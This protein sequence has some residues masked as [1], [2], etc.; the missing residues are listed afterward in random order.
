MPQCRIYHET[1][2][3]GLVAL[4][5]NVTSPAGA[6]EITLARAAQALAD[7]SIRITRISRFYRTPCMPVGAG[8]DFVN[9][10]AAIETAL[11]AEAVLDRLHRIEAQF[12]RTRQARW[13]ARPLDMDLLDL[14]GAIRPDRTT[15]DAWRTLPPVEQAHHAP[16]D[17]IL[18]H[19][20]LQDRGFV[21]VPLAEIAPDWRHPILDRTAQE[22]LDALPEDEKTAIFPIS[23]P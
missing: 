2:T 18:P 11:T 7:E 20:R 9:A 14:G 13:A 15:H 4:G 6:P 19:P 21:L 17:L 16:A 3:K 5:G 8:P 10:V 1:D 23:L 22:M 12:G